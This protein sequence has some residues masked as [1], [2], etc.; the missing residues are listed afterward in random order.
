M[1]L[2]QNVQKK[3][4]IYTIVLNISWTTFVKRCKSTYLYLV[5][6]T[7]L[8]GGGRSDVCRKRHKCNGAALKVNQAQTFLDMI[9]ILAVFVS[10]QFAYTR[11]ASVYGQLVHYCETLSGIDSLWRILPIVFFFQS[12][13]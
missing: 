13:S 12:V 3:K 8:F 2:S 9:G 4:Y 5:T 1:C 7:L 11:H 6:C 10:A